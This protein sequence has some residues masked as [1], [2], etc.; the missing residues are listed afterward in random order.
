[1]L[2]ILLFPVRLVIGIVTTVFRVTSGLFE[3]LFGVLGG[4][5]MLL[6][7]MAVLLMI[8]GLIVY[9]VRRRKRGEKYWV[10][11]EEFTSYYQ[12]H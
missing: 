12:Q 6:V 1:M 9:A 8:A 2:D 3:M 4:F 5:M 7:G 10:D 11:G